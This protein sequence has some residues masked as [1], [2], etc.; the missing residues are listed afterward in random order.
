MKIKN[1]ITGH[2]SHPLADLAL[3]MFAGLS[4]AL[5][6]GLG[7]IP[8]SEGFVTML[9]GQGLPLAIVFAWAAALSEFVGGLFLAFGIATRP[10]AF[11]LTLTMLYAG[12]IRHAE[13]PFSSK[14]KA[15]LYAAIALFY[16]LRGAGQ[17]SV[18][19]MIRRP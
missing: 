17:Y 16:T 10:A 4:M 2:N 8:P 9:E 7:K 1:W 18:D 5:G 19:G 6:H 13:D 11:F 12:L 14:E 3:R 15:L